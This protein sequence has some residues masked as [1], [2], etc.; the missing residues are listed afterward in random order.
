[1]TSSDDLRALGL[2]VELVAEAGI[3]PALDPGAPSND[4]RG[5]GRHE[6]VVLP[7][8]TSAGIPN[9]ARAARGRAPAR[10]SASA[11]KDVVLALTHNGSSTVRAATD[12]SRD[13]VFAIDAVGDRDGRRDARRGPAPWPSSS[14]A[15]SNR[16]PATLSTARSGC[17]RSRQQVAG[18]DEAAERVAVQH[19]G[20][21]ARAAPAR[22]PAARRGRRGTATSA[23]RRRAGRPTAHAAVVVGLTSRPAAVSW[24]PTCS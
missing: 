19:D 9:P 13:S 5:R 4:L 8:R 18:G 16:G 2:V 6:P 10:R 12:G 23:R 17:G 1:M 7:W 20:P 3:G 11:P 22:P 14:R 15:A 24:S 21:P